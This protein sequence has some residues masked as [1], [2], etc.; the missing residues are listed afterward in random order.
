MERL[1]ADDLTL[2]RVS[3]HSSQHAAELMGYNNFAPKVTTWG[4]DVNTYIEIASIPEST[5]ALFCIQT[6][7]AMSIG[8][9]CYLYVSRHS[10]GNNQEL[11]GQK[12]DVSGTMNIYIDKANN[13]VYVKLGSYTEISISAAFEKMSGYI[14]VESKNTVSDVSGMKEVTEQLQ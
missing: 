9:V 2:R 3:D 7:H 13:K 8:K 1:G 4:V 14:T 12:K 10:S 6:A 5:K 11:R